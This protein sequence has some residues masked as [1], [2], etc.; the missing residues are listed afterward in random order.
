M[1]NI[2]LVAATALLSWVLISGIGNK[3]DNRQEIITVLKNETDYFAK[4]DFEKWSQQWSHAPDVLFTYTVNNQ[5]NV[6]RGWEQLSKMIKDAMAEYTSIKPNYERDFHNITLDGNLA[7][8]HFT[9]KDSL[10]GTPTT[11][12]ETRTLKRE[13]GKWK[14]IGS[15]IINITSFEQPPSQEP[16][17]MTM[18]QMK[19]IIEDKGTTIRMKDGWGGMAVLFNTIAADTGNKTSEINLLEGLKD[20]SCQVPHWGYIVD[21]SLTLKYSDGKIEELKA[22]E[23]FYMRP[24]HVP[25]SDN[26]LTIVDFS[27]EKELKAL[28]A[29]M[30]KKMEEAQKKK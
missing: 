22:G 12:H 3:P 13:G 21:G 14:L 11:K 17:H 6:A 24:G 16:Y 30:A 19:P 23:V 9:Q 2:I 27:P 7:V 15:Q 29:H 25:I 26:K 10:D 1:R 18:E 5:A 28:F 4:K 8:V 20:N